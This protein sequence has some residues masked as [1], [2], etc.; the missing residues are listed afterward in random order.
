MQHHQ[1]INEWVPTAHGYSN[2]LIKR[3][4]IIMIQA[5]NHAMPEK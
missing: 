3:N 2:L 1:G 5:K 4:L